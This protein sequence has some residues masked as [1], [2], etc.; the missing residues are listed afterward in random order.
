[1]SPPYGCHFNRDPDPTYRNILAHAHLLLAQSDLA[2]EVEL[3]RVG[4]FEDLAGG[5]G[6][7]QT[8]VVL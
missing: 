4:V 2:R 6:P 8:L 7:H 3:V 5:V 1:M